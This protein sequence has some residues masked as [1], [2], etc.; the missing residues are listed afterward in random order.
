MSNGIIYDKFFKKINDISKTDTNSPLFI[1][2]YP[3]TINVNYNSIDTTELDKNIDLTKNAIMQYKKYLSSI[4]EKTSQINIENYVD[5]YIDT[6]AA[7]ALLRHSMTI[8]I[9]LQKEKITQ[10]KKENQKQQDELAR[11]QTN[12]QQ[13]VKDA[14][15]LLKNFSDALKTTINQCKEH[16]NCQTIEFDTVDSIN[17]AHQLINK[18]ILDKEREVEELNSKVKEL[19]ELIKIGVPI[20]A[21]LPESS[22]F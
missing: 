7:F 17:E 15:D 18:Y 22:R 4:K 12:V 13:Q 5:T 1:E 6:L 16:D 9:L 11:K 21:T 14:K 10:N 19:G 20:I 8:F 2:K 3:L